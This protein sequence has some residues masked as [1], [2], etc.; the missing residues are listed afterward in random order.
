MKL[1]NHFFL[2]AV[3]LVVSLCSIAPEIESMECDL[4]HF[5][6]GKAN[7]KT[8]QL[9]SI[10]KAAPWD[11]FHSEPS[12]LPRNWH[13]HKAKQNISVY[14][15][16]VEIIIPEGDTYFTYKEKV[17]IGWHGSYNPPHGML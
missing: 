8:I 1:F 3:T 14:Y 17:A 7:K 13:K 5:C 10:V 9:E 4:E 15:T 12:P 2:S 11:C 16:G 6:E